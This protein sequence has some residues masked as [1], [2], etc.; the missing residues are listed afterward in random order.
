M[1]RLSWLMLQHRPEGRVRF[2]LHCEEKEVG[3]EQKELGGKLLG[4]GWVR[5][6]RVQLHMRRRVGCCVIYQLAMWGAH[7]SEGTR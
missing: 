4:A 3:C 7:G 5:S 1:L 6:V 2:L